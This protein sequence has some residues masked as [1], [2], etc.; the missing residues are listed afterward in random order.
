MSTEASRK[1]AREYWNSPRAVK[2]AKTLDWA[3]GYTLTLAIVLIG[4]LNI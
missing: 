4:S 3:M 2:M 1:A